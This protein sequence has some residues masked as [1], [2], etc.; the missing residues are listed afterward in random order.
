MKKP[1]RTKRKKTLFAK[2]TIGA[3][4]F[5]ILLSYLI[6]KFVTD[7]FLREASQELLGGGIIL[8]V[9]GWIF[10]RYGVKIN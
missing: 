4:L 7:G 10:V 9:L 1:K 6:Y 2:V 3:G 5:L 8:I